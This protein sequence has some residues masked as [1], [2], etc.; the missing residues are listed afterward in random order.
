MDE[1]NEQ[2]LQHKQLEEKWKN[3]SECEKAEYLKEYRE[4]SS[5]ISAREFLV[6]QNSYFLLVI[7]KSQAE[8]EYNRSFFKFAKTLPENR[9]VDYEFYL[10][11]PVLKKPRIPRKSTVKMED[12]AE[13]LRDIA[14]LKG[15]KSE[16]S[17]SAV[18][19]G[20][21]NPELK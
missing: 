6:I 1:E 9:Q 10:D 16:A 7:I 12:I 8:R 14:E 3:L 20:S 21:K 13:A 19:L 11:R 17:N 15:E 2:S 5:C 4:V 18:Q